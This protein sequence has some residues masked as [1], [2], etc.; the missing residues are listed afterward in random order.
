MEKRF[1]NVSFNCV[2]VHVSDSEADSA[3]DSDDSDDDVDGRGGLPTGGCPAAG[4]AVG[5]GASDGSDVA[6]VGDPGD[7]AAGDGGGG[8]EIEYARYCFLESC[9]NVLKTIAYYNSPDC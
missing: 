7:G 1:Y 6:P 2:G 3:S 4:G 8:D 5:D 9:N